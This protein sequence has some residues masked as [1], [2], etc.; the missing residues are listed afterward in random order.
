M[1]TATTPTP[2]HLWII[3]VVLLLWNAVGAFDYSATQLKLDFYMSN[4]SQEQLDY[5]Y[6]F[7]VWMVAAWATAVWSAVLG[8]VALLAR[9][10]WA[11]GLFALTLIGLLI[12]SIYNFGMSDG[13]KIMGQEGV[14]FTGVIWLVS[15]LQLIYSRAMTKRGV[16]R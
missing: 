16:L 15:V 13:A 3:G 12:S 4:F 7:P 2:V 9:K 5:F 1:N 11:V 14:I 6:G 8:A 10:Q